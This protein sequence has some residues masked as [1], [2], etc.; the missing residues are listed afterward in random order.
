M[1]GR[2]LQQYPIDKWKIIPRSL[3][4]TDHKTKYGMAYQNGILPSIDVSLVVILAPTNSFEHSVTNWLTLPQD[5]MLAMEKIFK[6]LNHMFCQEPLKRCL[7]NG[8]IDD[9]YGKEF[10]E[11]VGFSFWLVAHLDNG[12]IVRVKPVHRRSKQYINYTPSWVKRYR[13]KQQ[14][15][16]K[17]HYEPYK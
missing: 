6:Q 17:F 1:Q 5:W 2:L 8:I 4:I 14:T 10:K 12:D 11:R 7:E 15:V 13:I 3:I 16:I 9:D